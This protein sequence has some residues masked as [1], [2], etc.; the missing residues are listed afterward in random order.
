MRDTTITIATAALLLVSSTAFAQRTPTKGMAG[1]GAAI[2]IANPSDASLASGFDV[3]VGLDGYLTSRVSIRA[4]LGGSWWD[5]QNR[6]FTGD[7][8]PVRFDGNIVYNWEGG[9][10]H[11]FVTAG[12]GV[13]H[14]KSTTGGI[15][16]SDTKL[17]LNLGGGV[18][19][20]LDRRTTIT[21]QALY[22]AVDSIDTRFAA[23]DGSYWTLDFGVKKYFGGRR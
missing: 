7:V 5:V 6:G 1:V 4:Q 3:A 10:W 9:A 22:H 15:E 2:G 23:F 14:Y 20:F 11:P 13:Y 8:K 21:G 19:Y 16:A 12:P 18:E 17:G